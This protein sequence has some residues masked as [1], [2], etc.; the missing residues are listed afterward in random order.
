[1]NFPK[2]L[3]AMALIFLGTTQINAQ[4]FFVLEWGEDIPVAATD[5]DDNRPKIALNDAGE[6]VIIWGK[7]TGPI[8]TSVGTSEGFTT[9]VQLNPEGT[10]TYNADWTG[11]EVAGAN[12]EMYAVFQMEPQNTMGVHIVHSSD[13]GLTWSDTIRVDLL[14]YSLEQ[15]RYPNIAV[16]E[17]GQPMV[18]FMKFEGN[19]IEPHYV[20]STSSD[21]G[22]TFNSDVNASNALVPGEACDC[23]MGE[24]VASPTR[25][26]MLFRNND[27]NIREMYAVSSADGGQTFDQNW[28]VDLTE[29]YSNTCFSSGPDGFVAGDKLYVAFRGHVEAGIRAHFSVS[30]VNNGVLEMHEMVDNNVAQNIKQTAVRIAGDANVRAVVWEE[31]VSLDH[32]IIAALEWGDGFQWRDTVNTNLSGQQINPDIIFDGTAFHITYTDKDLDQ[33]MYRKGVLATGVNVAGLAEESAEL[34]WNGQELIWNETGTWNLRIVNLNGQLVHKETTSKQRIDLSF[35]S[36]G[37]Y[38]VQ[39]WNTSGQMMSLKINK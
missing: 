38:G 16:T 5:F 19:W 20:V 29:T 24:L 7:N 34:Q 11:P 6:P 13:G 26:V 22:M 35:L 30:D 12:G 37:I 17:E 39:V 32:D 15:A 14:D 1:M 23:C 27:D 4:D 33:V 3:A 8:Y 2:L 21:F 31:Y 9:P 10:T 18:G 36:T 25:N 28:A